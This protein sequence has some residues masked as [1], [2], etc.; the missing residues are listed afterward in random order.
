MVPPIV[1]AFPTVASPESFLGTLT[2]ISVGP[3]DPDLITVKALKALQTVDVVAFP[4]GRQ[5]A[6]GLAQQMIAPHLQVHQQQLPLA[7]PFVTDPK[8]LQQAWRRAAEQ[9][10]Q[11]LAQGHHVGFACEGDISFYGTF[12][13]LARALQAAHPEVQINRIPGVCSP[14]AAVSALG[15]PL[16]MQSDRLAI[17]PAF[18]GIADLERTLDWAEVVVLMKVSSVYPQVW[19]LLHRRRLLQHSWVIERASQASERIYRDLSK[20][21]SLDLPYFSLMVVRSDTNSLV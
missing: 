6:P 1:S 4:E 10:W 16:T 19:Q 7:F 17:L 2:G 8:V 15:I 21:P 11:V 9:V 5:G 13:Y 18:Y 14:L 12:T 3:G 20:H